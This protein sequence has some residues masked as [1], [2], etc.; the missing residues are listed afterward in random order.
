MKRTTA[1]LSAVVMIIGCLAMAISASAEGTTASF[2]WGDVNRDGTVSVEDAQQVLVRYVQEIA[3][4]Y[5]QTPGNWAAADVDNSGKVSVED[6]QLILIKYVSVSVAGLNYF[7]PVESPIGYDEE[8]YLVKD[9]P[10]YRMPSVE[11]EFLIGRVKSGTT[12][13]IIQ[14]MGKDWYRFESENFISSYL[15]VP[16]DVWRVDLMYSFDK[17][18]ETTE[19]EETTTSEVATTTTSTTKATTTTTTSATTTATSKSGAPHT[20]ASTVSTTVKSTTTT[21]TTTVK[22]ETT[23]TSATTTTI[24]TTTAVTTTV[25][26]TTAKVTTTAITTT[27]PVETT[28]AEA[29]MPKFKAGDVIEFTGTSWKFFDEITKDGSI[30]YLQSHDR[31]T[32]LEAATIGESDTYIVQLGERK[33]SFTVAGEKYKY[34][35]KLN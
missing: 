7:F 14:Y 1:F 10:V 30:K 33:Y 18:S 13:K 29:R 5:K 22:P 9:F 27:V 28:T 23:T 2:V 34:F 8:V 24:T 19:T 31:F 26:T 11:E 21:K 35:F 3:G 12:I 15:Y 20:T 6:A 17:K 25:T 16:Q 4:N 32:I